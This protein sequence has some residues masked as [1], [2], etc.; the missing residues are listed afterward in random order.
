MNF[1]TVEIE[2]VLNLYQDE[3]QNPEYISE[4]SGIEI[5][6]VLAILN[7]LQKQGD[8]TGFQKIERKKNLNEDRILLFSEAII[9][10]EVLKS[11]KLDKFNDKR[12][13]FDEK[14]I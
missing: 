9:D 7:H 4:S 11:L 1:T 5:D 3:S 2:E 8:I 14:E 13:F 12:Y 10:P 6:K